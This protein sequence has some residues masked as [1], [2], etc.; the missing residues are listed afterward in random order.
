[1]AADL[2]VTPAL[3]P[4]AARVGSRAPG[5]SARAWLAATIVLTVGS[6]ATALALAP[7]GSAAPPEGLAF[8][9]FVGSSVH[10]ASTGW[11]FT[12][13]QARAHMRRHQARFVWWP[14]ALL[15][16]AGAIAF[17]TPRPVIY[18]FL[19]PYFGWQFFHYQKQNLGLAALAASACRVAPL[20]TAERG[21]L[22]AA[23]L[24]AIGALVARPSQLQLPIAH[25]LR[26][27][28]S[29]TLWSQAPWSEAPW[30]EVLW[31]A[32]ALA[33]AAS[34]AVG[35]GCLVRRRRADRPAGF[36]AAYL[37]ALAFGV[38]VFAFRSPYASVAGLTIAHGLQYLLLMG[39]VAGGGSGGRS[40]VIRLA[41]LCNIAL[42]G[43]SVLSVASDQIAA[44]PAGRI[45]FGLFLG[46]VMAHFVIDAGIWRMRD[47]FPRAFLAARV[48]Y[49]VPA[50]SRQAGSPT[51][52]SA[53]DIR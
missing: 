50:A 26:G 33:F 15:T 51:D 18:W 36:C 35:L 52:P 29:E 31:P 41:A 5:R 2:E 47:A 12:V 11:F 30:S 40:R 38:P 22:R 42:L 48:P 8:L 34:V 23:G 9:L 43:G 44:R 21:A 24:A 4:A 17:L 25:A 27:P 32:A 1:V 49:L 53:P 19:L 7:A 13:P 10:V 14:V 6:V 20:S 45:L 28:W 39:L 46:A 37:A 16:G 3:A